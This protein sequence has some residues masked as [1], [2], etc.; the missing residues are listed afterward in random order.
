M[1]LSKSCTQKNIFFKI[2]SLWGW[3]LV[4]NWI[5]K[6]IATRFRSNS[7]LRALFSKHEGIFLLSLLS[8]ALYNFS[9]VG[10]RAGTLETNKMFFNSKCLFWW[11]WWRIKF[12]PRRKNCLCA[13]SQKHFWGPWHS[14]NRIIILSIKSNQKKNFSRGFLDW[15]LN[16]CM[17][18]VLCSLMWP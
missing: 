16:E 2:L 14:K 17:T 9:K 8:G 4:K 6:Y 11:M 13:A 3:K 5:A 12:L 15:N 7:N 10:K 1:A 18:R